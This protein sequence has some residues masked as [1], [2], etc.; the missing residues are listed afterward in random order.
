M[1]DFSWLDCIEIAIITISFYGISLWL[2]RDERHNLLGYFYGLCM[3]GLLTLFFPMPVI[4]MILI[5]GWPVI[6]VL[7]IIMHQETLQKNCISLTRAKPEHVTTDNFIDALLRACLQAKNN[8]KHVVCIIEGNDKLSDLLDA[9]LFINA[10]FNEALFSA[11]MMSVSYDFN[12][13]VWLTGGGVLK[14]LNASWRRVPDL[15]W[16]ND[17]AHIAEWKQNALLFSAKADALILGLSSGGFGFFDAVIRGKLLE[18]LNVSQV[19]Q[20]IQQYHIQVKEYAHIS[21]TQGKSYDQKSG[22]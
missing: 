7:F 17:Q 15:V 11:L 12:K 9:S 1:I 3:F 6:A 4:H 14:A 13:M 2:Y 5:N 19:Q 22:I 10:P 20:L 18:Q 16:H 8:N 21:L